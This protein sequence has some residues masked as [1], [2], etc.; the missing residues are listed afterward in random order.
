[1]LIPGRLQLSRKEERAVEQLLADHAGEPV[2]L[3][4]RDAGE[5][6]PVLVH[7]GDRTFEVAKSGATAEVTP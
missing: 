2:S 1:M 6:G 4:R 5:R 3:T 7:V